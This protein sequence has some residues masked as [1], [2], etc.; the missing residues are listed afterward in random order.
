MHKRRLLC[1]SFPFHW[2]DALLCHELIPEL[3]F[4]LYQVSKG[5]AIL[6]RNLCRNF[7]FRSDIE[8]A[9]IEIEP[10][11]ENNQ[12]ELRINLNDTYAAP[13]YLVDFAEVCALVYTK[14]G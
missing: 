14:V 2:R 9:E 13:N 12:F 10:E 4:I 7:R 6:E 1:F 3:M 5:L 11:T 8:L